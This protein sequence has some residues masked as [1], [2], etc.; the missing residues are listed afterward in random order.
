MASATAAAFR[1]IPAQFLA[2]AQRLGPA[3]AYQVRSDAGW[4]PTSWTDYANTVNSAARALVALGIRPGDN[5]CILGFNRPEWSTTALAAMMVGARTAGIYWTSAPEEVGYIVA[6]S[7]C[8]L[9]L[10]EDSNQLGKLGALPPELRHVVLMRG[11]AAAGPLQLGWDDF[12]AGGETVPPGEV[13]RRMEAIAPDD[14]GSM[15]YTSGTTGHPKAVM[16]THASLAWVG[17]ALQ[18]ALGANEHDH[19][20]SYLPLAHIAEQMVTIHAQAVIGYQ[21]HYA[22]SLDQLGDHLKEVRPTIFFGVPRVWERM[23]KAIEEKLGA[24]TGVKAKLVDWAMNAAK[25]WHETQR[26]GGQ[27]GPAA[28]AARALA[29]ALVLNKVRRALGFDAARWVY[30]GAAPISP[31]T[32]SFFTGLDLSIREVYGLSETCGPTTLGLAPATPLGSVGQAIPGVALK[33]AEDGELMVRG[34]NLFAGYAGR[35]DD[36]AAVLVDGWLATG[37]L[38]RLDEAGNVFI[39][40]RK[41]DLLITSGGKNISPANIEADLMNIPLV[42]HAIVCGEGRNYVAALI[43]LSEEAL[44]DFA[45]R[46]KLPN[47]RLR[48]RPEVLKYLQEEI[49]RVNARHFRASWVRRFTVLDAPLSIEGGDLTATMKI[50]R[51]RVLARHQAMIDRMYEES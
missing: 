49:D 9:I 29:R 48:R 40:G 12:L 30:S 21:V 27:P 47:D 16:L 3:A 33:L 23:Q 2:N 20:I 8:P 34:P 24:A 28:N 39:T 46:H 10:V 35:T 25:R 31:A 15:I 13:A 6:H 5:I 41:K 26:A 42:E 51:Q 1:S 22:R 17:A 50:R 11:T 38:A 18:T 37:D 14:I 32:L 36:T 19:V 4:Q 45:A 43:T 7:R 44:T